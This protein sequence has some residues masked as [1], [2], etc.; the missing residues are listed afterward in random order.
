MSDHSNAAWL[1]ELA[2]FTDV[3]DLLNFNFIHVSP[4]RHE[5]LLETERHQKLRVLKFLGAE[6]MPFL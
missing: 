6:W 1:N 2:L 3:F 4:G 5:I